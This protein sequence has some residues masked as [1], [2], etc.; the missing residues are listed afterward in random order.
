MYFIDNSLYMSHNVSI[1]SI[2]AILLGAFIECYDFLLYGNFSHIFSKI[3]FSHINETLS[4]ILS[5]VIFAIAFF[6]RPFG[7]LLFGYIGDKYGRRVSLFISVSLLMISMGGIAFLPLFDS[8]GI[9]SPILLVLLRTLQGLSFGGEAGAIVLM[10]ESVK[11]DQVMLISFAHFVIAILGGAAG[12]FI[13][14]LCYSFISEAE[15]YVWGWRVP[16][17]I[18]LVMSTLLPVL[19]NSI[20]ESYQY[21]R[22]KSHNK[23]ISKVPILDI[24]LHHKKFCV[25]I[26]SVVGISNMLFYMFFVFLNIQQQ[27]NITTYSFLIL[28]MLI[29]GFLSLFM[30]KR[31]RSENVIIVFQVL[32][33]VCIS[34]VV[35][36]FGCYSLVTYFVL[37]IALGI[38]ATPALSMVILLFPVNIRQTGFSLCYSIAIA[39]FG[40]TTPAICLWLVKV[41]GVSISPILYFDVCALL[42]LYGLFALKKYNMV[43]KV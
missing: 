21:L 22:Y 18:G 1:K 10:A 9:L 23:K 7:S 32:F 31:Y 39:V 14:Q 34:C 16:F 20:E 15:F 4:L 17:I 36:F 6:V 41:T 13:F 42:S 37:A 26:F 8:I 19:R 12:S 24:I 28:V 40:G 33:V 2:I 35:S 3:F 27:V 29:S 25:I 30:Y 38:Y 43:G 11:E 5:F